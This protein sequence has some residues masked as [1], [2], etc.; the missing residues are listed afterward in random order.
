[1]VTTHPGILPGACA[2]TR[3]RGLEPFPTQFLWNSCPV[4]LHLASPFPCVRIHSCSPGG[5]SSSGSSSS[6]GAAVPTDWPTGQKVRGW[7]YSPVRELPAGGFTH[8]PALSA[9][10]ECFTRLCRDTGPPR[11]PLHRALL[12][13]RG[14]C[15]AQVRGAGTGWKERGWREERRKSLAGAEP[16]RGPSPHSPRCSPRSGG[17]GGSGEPGVPWW[18][19]QRVAAASSPPPTPRA[20]SSRCYWF[21]PCLWRR[22][23]TYKP[24]SRLPLY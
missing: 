13:H 8:V 1:M 15:R 17:V 19:Q 23:G 10:P 16:T 6:L 5:S 9:S 18:W 11:S 2:G 12:S 21:S 3:G 22:L 24:R 7:G 14:G 4:R 20:P